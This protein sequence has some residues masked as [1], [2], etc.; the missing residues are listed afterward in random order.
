[1]VNE[2]IHDGHNDAVILEEL[3]PG[4]RWGP[5]YGELLTFGDP[6]TR[7]PASDHLEGFHPCDY[8]LYRRVLV[9]AR[10]SGTGLPAWLYVVGNRWT[11]SVKELIGGIWR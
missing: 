8:C 3:A 2:A 1:M 5:V 9:P 4:D 6:E 10:A 7:L 11:G